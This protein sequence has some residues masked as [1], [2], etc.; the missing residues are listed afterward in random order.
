MPPKR[1]KRKGGPQEGA[2]KPQTENLSEGLYDLETGEPAQYHTAPY[3]PSMKAA[4]HALGIDIQ[5]LKDARARDCPAFRTGGIVHRVQ[6]VDWLKTHGKTPTPSP[7]NTL[8][9]TP[10]SNLTPPPDDLPIEEDYN[11]TEEIGGVGQTLKSLQ[12]YER[13]CKREVDK[14]EASTTLHPATKADLLKA[15]QTAWLKV[16]GLLLD[17]DTKV[18]QAKRES[19]E[20]IPLGDAQKGVQ[21]LIAWHTVAMSDAL[22][23]VIPELEGKNKYE[24]AVLLDPALRSSMYR[25]FKLGA[26]LG[27]IP[28]W[29]TKTASEAVKANP[30]LSLTPPV[31]LD[32]I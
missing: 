29:V 30:P 1:K 15:K 4:S 25:N 21:A 22:R 2:G 13:R 27:K 14:V 28:E 19:G 7:E 18:S 12:A 8:T 3:F 6:I 26:S 11:V 31:T 17:Y 10:E 16:S 24:I 20:L 23:N 5:I 9:P 32:E